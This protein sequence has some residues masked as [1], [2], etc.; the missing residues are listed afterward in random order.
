MKDTS[1]NSDSIPNEVEKSKNSQ[2]NSNKECFSVLDDV[3]IKIGEKEYLGLVKCGPKIPKILDFFENDNNTY[4][5][6]IQNIHHLCKL[7]HNYPYICNIF[8]F[9]H[10]DNNQQNI[11]GVLMK[12]Y[13][14]ICFDIE[15]ESDKDIV[16]EFK[17]QILELLSLLAKNNDFQ[18]QSYSIPFEYLAKRFRNEITS[19]INSQCIIDYIRLIKSV[20]TEPETKKGDNLPKNYFYCSGNCIVDTLFNDK[21]IAKLSTIGFIMWIYLPFSNQLLK[22]AK[23]EPKMASLI[24][25]EYNSEIKIQFLLDNNHLNVG[26]GDKKLFNIGIHIPHGQWIK[27]QLNMITTTSI[28]SKTHEA[29]II[30]EIVGTKEAKSLR[31][32]FP[33]GIIP[34]EIIVSKLTLFENFIGFWTSLVA[35]GENVKNINEIFQ[36]FP[37]GI[38]SKNLIKKFYAN[39]NKMLNHLLFLY[40]PYNY[41]EKEKIFDDNINQIIG[42]VLTADKSKAGVHYKPRNVHNIHNIGGNINFLPVMEYV[43]SQREIINED[44]FYELFSL[45]ISVPMMKKQNFFDANYSNYFS[46][47]GLFCENISKSF[48]TTKICDILIKAKDSFFIFYIQFAELKE[49]NKNIKSFIENIYLNVKIIT[50]FSYEN[51]VKLNKELCKSIEAYNIKISTIFD[52][53]KIWI[54]IRKLDEKNYEEFCCRNHARMFNFPKNKISNPEMKYKLGNFDKVLSSL[55]QEELNDEQSTNTLTLFQMLTLDL[56]PCI[57]LFIIKTF[58]NLLKKKKK[59]QTKND[60]QEKLRT[61]LMENNALEI[62]IYSL[63]ISLLDIKR[64]L[65]KLFSLIYNINEIESNTNLSIDKTFLLIKHNVLPNNLQMD[66]CGKSTFSQQNLLKC[67]NT[68]SKLLSQKTN[69]LDLPPKNNKTY[70]VESLNDQEDFK[71]KQ[72]IDLKKTNTFCSSFNSS[73]EFDKSQDSV[74]L[75]KNNNEEE[76]C[77]IDSE[78]EEPIL[79]IEEN[80]SNDDKESCNYFEELETYFKVSH[81][82]ENIYSDYLLFKIQTLA[83]HCTDFISKRRQ[84]QSYKPNNM[85]NFSDKTNIYNKYNLTPPHT[86]QDSI[87]LENDNTMS[88]QPFSLGDSNISNNS[89]SSSGKIGYEIIDELPSTRKRLYYYFDKNIYNFQVKIL[90]NSIYSWLEKPHIQNNDKLIKNIFDLLLKLTYSSKNVY[91]I[92]A[93]LQNI[94]NIISSQKNQPPYYDSFLKW[95]YQSEEFYYFIIESMFLRNLIINCK[96]Y[97][98]PFNNQ[99]SLNEYCEILNNI[100]YL[101]GAI[102]KELFIFP[103][104][105]NIN[106]SKGKHSKKAIDTS[107]TV[108]RINNLDML[109]TWGLY[110]KICYIN[111][112]EPNVNHNKSLSSLID[113]TIKLLLQDGVELYYRMQF[114]SGN[115]DLVIIDDN[116]LTLS[117]IIYEYIVIYKSSNEIKNNSSSF[118][119]LNT[120][121]KS[122]SNLYF[123]SSILGSIRYNQ[124]KANDLSLSTLWSDYMLIKVYLSCFQSTWKIETICAKLGCSIKSNIIK[125]D[126]SKK[127]VIDKLISQL[128]DGKKGNSFDKEIELFT[129]VKTKHEISLLRILSNLLTTTLSVTQ[130]EHESEI[131][132]QEYENFFFY[133]FVMSHHQSKKKQE[134]ITGFMPQFV[135][136][137]IFSFSFLL[138][139]IYTQQVAFSKLYK[140]N[141]IWITYLSLKFIMVYKSK[142]EKRGMLKIKKNYTNYPIIKIFYETLLLSE[143]QTLFDSLL[144]EKEI[145]L[146]KIEQYYDENINLWKTYLFENPAVDKDLEHLFDQNLYKSIVD[147]RYKNVS[148]YIPLFDNRDNI[149]PKASKNIIAFHV[150]INNNYVEKEYVEEINNIKNKISQ[151]IPLFGD[152]IEKYYDNASTQM[153]LKK[154]MY[155]KVKKKLFSWNSTWS[156]HKIFYKETKKIREKLINHYTKDFGMTILT[157]ILDIKYYLP[158]FSQFQTQNLF[159]NNENNAPYRIVLDIEE[160]LKQGTK[161]EEENFELI[162]TPNNYL[163]NIHKYSFNGDM[164]KVYENLHQKEKN[165]HPELKFDYENCYY[166]CCIVKQTHHIVGKVFFDSNKL[167]FTLRNLDESDKN[168]KLYDVDRKTCS[169]SIFIDHSKSK[170]FVSLKILYSKIN[171]ILHRKYF[172][173]NSAL[174]I[175][176]NENKSYYFNFMSQK[177]RDMAV[178]E[179]ISKKAIFHEIKG[180][181]RSREDSIYGYINQ[182]TSKRKKNTYFTSINDLCEKQWLVSTISN[183]EML[184][185]VNFLGNRSY[186]DLF[187]YPVFPWPLQNFSQNKINFAANVRDLSLP[188]GM[189]DFDEDSRARKELY[190]SFMDGL[191]NDK[192]KDDFDMNDGPYCYGSHFSNP[193]YVSHYLVR[194]FPYTCVHVEM[195]GCKFDDPHRQF[196]SIESSFKCVSSQKCDIRELI[197]ELFCLSELYY[198]INNLNMGLENPDVGLPKFSHNKAYNL[199]KKMRQV[200]ENKDFNMNYWIDLIFGYLQRGKKAEEHYNVYMAYTYD[201]NVNLEK[202][203]DKGEI[204]CNLRMF[205]LG[206]MPIQIFV[207]PMQEKHRYNDDYLLLKQKMEPESQSISKLK[208]LIPVKF[209]NTSK[210]NYMIICN[211]YMI[212]DLDI[213]N[214]NLTH[215]AFSDSTNQYTPKNFKELSHQKINSLYTGKKKCPIVAYMNGEI[216]AQGGF[217]GGEIL[218]FQK[219]KDD[220]AIVK[221]PFSKYPVTCLEVDKNDMFGISGDTKGQV[222]VYFNILNIKWQFKTNMNDHHKEITSIFIDNNLNAVG[223]AAYDG[224]IMIY[225]LGRFSLVRS[226]KVDF[227]IGDTQLNYADYIFLS[228]CPHPCFVIYNKAL[229]KYKSYT[230]NGTEI[231]IKTSKANHN[232]N[233]NNINNKNDK[234]TSN[235]K[236]KYI[237]S[238][239]VFKDRY[240]HNNYLIV[241]MSDGCVQIRKFPSMRIIQKIEV[242]DNKPVN[243][244]EISEKGFVILLLAWSEGNLIK[245][246]PAFDFTSNTV[247]TTSDI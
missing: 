109:L 69:S 233:N 101:G 11:E 22:E 122:N 64:K 227:D 7:I 205:E 66:Y 19:K 237:T 193:M 120:V 10:S 207:E 57:Q 215:F 83:K 173:R 176:T 27:I 150:K 149:N 242:F 230:I 119:E 198:N 181:N 209:V 70:S 47:L 175:F 71:Y 221:S 93:F 9:Y 111:F 118:L 99:I 16:K 114:T 154:S 18:K 8:S 108:K 231:E 87:V 212:I 247:A 24:S 126:N 232:T 189:L 145:T 32:S 39:S 96:N 56:S 103:K 51:R 115:I 92:E 77:L 143:N 28:L 167:E 127:D 112:E 164:W 203:E 4:F 229:M 128:I 63:S 188:I 106:N 38:Y 186:R 144:K 129:R 26:Y 183:F 75:S 85:K 214:S 146:D 54:Y 67:T 104:Q 124:V 74:N 168:D 58:I 17:E 190:K 244:L 29:E 147:T 110:Q 225:T 219:S 84:D 34:K 184:M 52:F 65:L 170:D 157:P 208:N 2:Q 135:E 206:V 48:F 187:Q 59:K 238:F 169:G 202:T 20:Y 132:L 191:K 185:W 81:K 100:Y 98:I 36:K 136:I 182:M 226:I 49:K 201:G 23:S 223:T 89:S 213:K 117:N 13:I 245:Y 139:R 125:D 53:P 14:K 37:V 160:V 172:Y 5:D 200:L 55:I 163:Y 80:Q 220:S 44:V 12:L 40:T 177:E 195:Q 166:K 217:W 123:P 61:I 97:K 151:I 50:K 196:L 236:K 218:V 165:I 137:I 1:S 216:I 41:Y 153:H 161:N 141:L 90:Y 204:K 171:Y 192:V 6:K 174:E 159:I 121:T 46:C 155:K 156:D 240:N 68:F 45:M 21:K 197:P 30:A 142:K 178:K 179:I 210:F 234:L 25:L 180:Y 162:G 91:L 76:N 243:L 158:N 3:F 199:T 152:K 82:T 73:F 79:N 31:C 246:I 131:W 42:N 60:I 228:N 43:Y 15:N 78:E 113:N 102:H 33:S 72:S 211:N 130:N 241:G 95:I 35:F 138:H 148:N 224:Y 140:K 94:Q 107:D 116:F 194:L 134:N 86:L 62:I 105:I 88:K 133:I 239:C 235:K 222:I